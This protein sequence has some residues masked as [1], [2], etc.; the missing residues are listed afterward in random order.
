MFDAR[1]MRLSF[2]QFDAGR[3]KA[4]WFSRGR[5]R[6]HAVQD[7]ELLRAMEALRPEIQVRVVSYGTAASVFE[8]AHVLVI[9]LGLPDSGSILD[10]P[11][12]A[13]KLAGWLDP[14]WVISHEE[15]P[16]L[17]GVKIFD[18]PTLMLT[19]WFLESEQYAMAALKYADRVLFLGSEGIFTEPEWIAGRV[20]YAGSMR[21]PQFGQ[22]ER[23]RVRE[24]LGIGDRVTVISVFPG[25]WTESTAP[26]VEDVIAA[27][28]GLDGPKKLLWAAADDCACT[29]SK[30]GMRDDVA[31]FEYTPQIERLMSA[32]DVA[33]TK[34]N[35]K[36]V[37]ELQHLGIR[38]IAIAFGRNA[39]DEI[40][41]RAL[42]TVPVLMK[43]ELSSN[44]LLQAIQHL[45]ASPFIAPEM[46]TCT[47]DDCA[48]MIVTALE[49]R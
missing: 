17:A 28:D 31:V 2:P 10:V 43:D 32:T 34:A 8:Q 35:R 41:V 5:G 29:R 12:L 9:D 18:K 3:R 11:V 13:G 6:G 40:A 46:P 45:R 23:S 16:A 26:I 38:T 48:R 47:P 7:L 37:F 24:E 36:S 49:A 21:R 42:S 33:I 1:G 25:S 27:F 39:A 44:T 20:Q 22:V 4:L 19:D 30:I 14:D 15:F